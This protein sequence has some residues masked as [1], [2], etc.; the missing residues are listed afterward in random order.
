MGWGASSYD[1]SFLLDTFSWQSPDCSKSL[2]KGIQGP[3][4]RF[5]CAGEEGNIEHLFPKCDYTQAVWKST[6]VEV[7]LHISIPQTWKDTFP[8]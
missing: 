4:K 6:L 3:S 8:W 5:L 7:D 2:K 1:K